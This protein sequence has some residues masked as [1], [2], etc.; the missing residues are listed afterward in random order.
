MSADGVAA[1][2]GSLAG[3]VGEHASSDASSQSEAVTLLC[4][5]IT[6]EKDAA[7]REELGREAYRRVLGL[8]QSLEQA[9][10][11]IRSAFEAAA[12]R[13]RQQ[14]ASAAAAAGSAS[15]SAVVGGAQVIGVWEAARDLEEAVTVGTAVFNAF[16][17]GMSELGDRRP[18]VA[19]VLNTQHL[20]EL[21]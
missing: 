14:A 17:S 12:D 6:V 18:K 5:S 13:G 3:A 16:V 1:A 21:V 9:V 15:A 11:G 4:A 7:R 20:R 2:G 10:A 19:R 8:A